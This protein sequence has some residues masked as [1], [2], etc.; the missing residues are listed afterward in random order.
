MQE[1]SGTTCHHRTSS[2]FWRRP[3]WTGLKQPGSRKAQS[4]NQFQT[5]IL[6]SRY[7]YKFWTGIIWLFKNNQW[8]SWALAKFQD[9]CMHVCMILTQWDR[10]SSTPWGQV[11]WVSRVGKATSASKSLL[12]LGGRLGCCRYCW[13]RWHWERHHCSHWD[14]R[15]YYCFHYCVA[16]ETSFCSYPLKWQQIHNVIIVVQVCVVHFKAFS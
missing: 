11:W 8:M 15:C 14:G 1:R 16:C 13:G 9:S 12:A 6:H 7:M 2:W 3:T 4:Y 5:L 10:N